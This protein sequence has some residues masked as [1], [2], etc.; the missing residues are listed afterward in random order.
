[1][2]V[3]AALVS[4]V[5]PG[6]PIVVAVN[7]PASARLASQAARIGAE[8]VAVEHEPGRPVDLGRLEAALWARSARVCALVHADWETGVMD[9]PQPACAL[10]RE[11]G[12]LALVDCRATLGAAPVEAAVWG[13][14]IVCAGAGVGLGAPAGLALLGLGPQAEAA[15]AARAAPPIVWSLD[16]ARVGC[17]DDLPAPRLAGLREALAACQAGGPEPVRATRRLRQALC[18]GLQALGLVLVGPPERAAAGLAAAFAPPGV[19]AARVR[20]RM[21][22]A[23]GVDVGLLGGSAAP[24]G[25]R[26]ALRGADLAAPDI[27][28][29]VTALAEA[30]SAE[31]LGVEAPPEGRAVDLAAALVATGRALDGA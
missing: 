5:Q 3:D 13:A 2:A 16:L 26:F 7:G 24:V 10:A 28:L 11:H 31:V 25:W 1:M 29:A 22:D 17:V 14:D 8:V 19:D 23:Y 30:L 20:L 27:R 9:D 12:A 21:L 15:L 18:A 4:L 6:E